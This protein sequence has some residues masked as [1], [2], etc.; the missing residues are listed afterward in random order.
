MIVEYTYVYSKSP[1]RYVCGVW[2]LLPYIKNNSICVS[3]VMVNNN[4][5]NRNIPLNDVFV[6]DSMICICGLGSHQTSNLFA[7]NVARRP[8][9]KA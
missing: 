3:F 8:T 6:C 4:N 2:V 1:Y 9:T 7:P 5:R